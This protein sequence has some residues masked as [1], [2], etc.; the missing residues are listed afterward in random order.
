MTPLRQRLTDD[1]R[2]RNYA[3]KTITTYVAA[4]ARFA[5]HFMVDPRNWTTG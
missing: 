2:I 3:P 5:Q 4:V 1:L